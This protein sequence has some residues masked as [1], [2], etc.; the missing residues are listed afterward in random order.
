MRGRCS[1][2]PPSWIL[3]L[4]ILSGCAAGPTR[5]IVEGQLLPRHFRFVTVVEQSGNEPGGW[6]AACIYLPIRRDTGDAFICKFGVE[7]PIATQADGLFSE[8]LA[9]R[10]SA[11]CANQAAYGVLSLATPETPLGVA[12][13][14]FK[15]TYNEIL[16]RSVRGSRVK[17]RCHERTTPVEI[18]Q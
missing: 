18:G 17:T 10:I 16:N 8:P 11:D 15:S 13:E 1:W 5:T 4:V 7:M 6:R 9:Q 3:V 12:C 2:C 14:G